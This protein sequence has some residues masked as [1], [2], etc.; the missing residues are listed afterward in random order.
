MEKGFSM[1]HPMTI[2][3]YYMAV[4]G[5]TIFVMHPVYMAI[6]FCGASA[7]EIYLNRRKGVIHV[8]AMIPIFLLTSLI[9]P[10]FSHR[11]M[12]RICY[13]PTGNPLTLESVIYGLASGFM[14]VTVILWFST[15]NK[16]MTS[17]RILCICGRIFPTV[18]MV[19]GM[20]LRFVPMY[21]KQARKVSEANE[22]LGVKY[23][24]KL[25]KIKQGFHTFG[26]MITWSLENAVTTADSMRARGYG[27]G[28]R[29]SFSL[30]KVELRDR[31]VI[32]IT[33]LLTAMQMFL[34][35]SGLVDCVYYPR[36]YMV[37]LKNA[38]AYICYGILCL[39]PVI[40]SVKEDMVWLRLQ[41]KI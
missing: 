17:D 11:G 29:S 33:V 26:I 18:G 32:F 23:I 8:C 25:R 1:Y 21:V 39:L 10:L 22:M 27:Q 2:A 24:G 20:V 34:F 4:V 6:S 37:G 15:F 35:I 30:Y 31:L 12:T 7:Y 28:V 16:V 5:T 3:S 36:F 9:N 14:I 38:G 40:I 41:S 13:F 19:F